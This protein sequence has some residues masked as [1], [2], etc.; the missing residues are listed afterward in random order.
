MNSVT[1][2]LKDLLYDQKRCAKKIMTVIETETN[3]NELRDDKKAI[4][5]SAV[6]G[7]LAALYN[8]FKSVLRAL[9]FKLADDDRHIPP[10]SNKVGEKE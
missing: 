4:I 7:E 3:Y 1:G 5:R 2:L 10:A 6:M 9:G 8:R